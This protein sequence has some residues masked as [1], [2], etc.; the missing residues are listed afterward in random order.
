MLSMNTLKTR[1]RIVV[2][3]RPL[4]AAIGRRIRAARLRAGLTQQALADGRYTKAYVSALENGLV[5]PSMAALNFLSGR[6]GL[7]AS[8][9]LTDQDIAFRRIDADYRLASGDWQSALDRFDDLADAAPDRVSLAHVQRGRAEALCR[10]DRTAEAVGAATRAVEAFEELKRPVD[11][12]LARYWLAFA[13]HRQENPDEARSLLRGVLDEIRGGLAV[14]SDFQVRV[15]VALASVETGQGQHGTALAYLEEARTMTADLDDRRQG[16]LLFTLAISH[17]DAG[18]LEAAIRAGIAGLALLQLANAERDSASLENYLALTYLAT[19]SRDRARTLAEI[20]HAEAERLDDRWLLSHV[21]DT[22]ARIVLDDD[23]ARALELADA[24][25]TEAEAV[26]NPKALLDGLVTRA[27]ALE[28]T[29]RRD[30]ALLTY[31][32][33]AAIARDHASPARVRDVLTAWADSLVAAGREK[34]AVPLYRE[35]LAGAR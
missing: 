15:L 3:D 2:D 11:A 17:R 29:D 4:A 26:D 23:P 10:L 28:R 24:A 5:K 20:A 21:L 35:A 16:T 13:Q 14:T 12:A 6:L 31:G 18:D 25:V 30:D 1:R 34:D 8:D 32:R 7:P 33:A 9:F 27:R 19:G 22:E